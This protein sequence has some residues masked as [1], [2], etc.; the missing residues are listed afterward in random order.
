MDSS[1][2]IL[3]FDFYLPQSLTFYIKV[4]FQL[5]LSKNKVYPCKLIKERIIEIKFND[6][7]NIDQ[8]LDLN[9]ND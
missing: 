3:D 6:I 1:W 8:W 5:E 2:T 7:W 9:F 4:I